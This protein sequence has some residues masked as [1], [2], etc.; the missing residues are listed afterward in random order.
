M[1][2]I[3]LTFD[4]ELFFGEN[5][6]DNDTVLFLPTKE[7]INGL[8]EKNV[9]GTFFVDVCSIAQHKKYNLIEYV[10]KFSEQLKY[11]IIM[12]QDVQL[13]IH[14]HW[15]NSKY[16]NGKWEFDRNHYRIHSYGFDNT[17]KINVSSII[18]SG[19]EYL[20]ETIKPIYSGYKCVAFRAG[21]FCLQP[22]EQLVEVLY[23]NGIR[24]DSSIAPNLSFS[25]DI[26]WY[27]YKHKIP[28]V[29]WN[30]GYD[31]EWWQ[32]SSNNKTLYEIPIGTEKKNVISFLIKKIFMPETIDFKLEQRRGS[33]INDTTQKS[34]LKRFKSVYKYI[35]DY[36]AISLDGYQAKYIYKQ[37]E[38]FYYI[39]KCD[40]NDHTIALIGHP[41]LSSKTYVKNIQEL[42]ELINNTTMDMK[43]TSI[44]EESN[45][46]ND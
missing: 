42:I 11:M 19:I 29:N 22:H 8:K 45:I 35:T 23:N 25:S 4:Y 41:K 44:F 31:S 6:F 14:S 40:K 20:N 46:L 10:K 34:I 3:C 5:Y 36:S 18:K 39:N 33:Y 43:I 30:I 21:G 1:L 2:K 38:K 17:Q 32:N 37:L 12:G 26:N 24:I 7:L 16:I 28:F 27:T 13:H 9:S 15:L